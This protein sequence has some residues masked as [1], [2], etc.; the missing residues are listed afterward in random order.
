MSYTIQEQP[1]PRKNYFYTLESGKWF[2][3][4]DLLDS[5]P[6]MKT[7]LVVR[8]IHCN[9]TTF[10]AIDF[11]GNH[12]LIGPDEEVVPLDSIATFTKEV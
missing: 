3:R 2:L 12:C 4:K 9:T 11:S 5:T 8:S 6:K 7:S 1:A 10:N